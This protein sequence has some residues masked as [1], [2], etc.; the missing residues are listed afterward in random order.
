MTFDIDRNVLRTIFRIN[1]G[2]MIWAGSLIASHLVAAVT[3]GATGVIAQ[4]GGLRV[5]L[6]AVNA[7]AAAA[8][9]GLLYRLLSNGRRLWAAHA[10]SNDLAVNYLGSTVA[11]LSLLGIVWT[12]ILSM[13][14][15]ICSP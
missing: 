1:A 3:C 13:M 10:P 15:N 6:I 7:I 14:S 12:T 11:F 5:F 4:M 2:W 9:I 8:A